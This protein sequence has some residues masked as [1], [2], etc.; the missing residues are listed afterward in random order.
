MCTYSVDI[1]GVLTQAG[2]YAPHNCLLTSA[3]VG[4]GRELEG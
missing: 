3:P 1:C 2:S 4:Q